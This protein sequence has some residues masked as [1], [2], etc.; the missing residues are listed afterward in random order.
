MKIITAANGKKS[1]AITKANWENIGKQAG[2][3]TTAESSE[4]RLPGCTCSTCP[5]CKGNTVCAKCKQC[6]RCGSHTPGCEG[7]VAGSRI[8]AHSV[9]IKKEAGFKQNIQNAWNA[10]QSSRNIGKATKAIQ[11]AIKELAS[12]VSKASSYTVQDDKGQ[13]IPVVKLLPAFEQFQNVLVEMNT[14]SQQLATAGQKTDVQMSNPFPAAPQTPS[15]PPVAQPAAEAKPEAAAVA[16]E[17]KQEVQQTTTAPQVAPQTPA[18]APQPQAQYSIPKTQP[19]IAK[20]LSTL[21]EEQV[22]FLEREVNN[23]RKRKAAKTTASA[24]VPAPAPAKV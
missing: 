12:A 7:C 10:F 20:W 18:P 24:Y 11:A 5:Q 19:E 2:W 22:Q 3:I 9:G 21:P 4:K 15:A 14:Q 13:V 8:E 23:L 17:T 6:A 16:P 1:I